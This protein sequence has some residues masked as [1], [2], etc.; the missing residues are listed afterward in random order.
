MSHIMSLL[1]QNWFFHRKFACEIP[2]KIQIPRGTKASSCRHN[3][4]FLSDRWQCSL[5]I[6]YVICSMIFGTQFL[7]SNEEMCVLAQVS[8]SW[9]FLYLLSSKVSLLSMIVISLLPVTLCPGILSTVPWPQA[10]V[11]VTVYIVHCVEWSSEPE[12]VWGRSPGHDW[13]LLLKA[14]WSRWKMLCRSRCWLG[15]QGHEKRAMWL[16]PL[17]CLRDSDLG[18]ILT[19]IEHACKTTSCQH[20]GILGK[21][22]GRG[23]L[24]LGRASRT[25]SETRACHPTGRGSGQA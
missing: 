22:L 19:W 15:D 9:I 3:S 1:F 23:L 2:Y 20:V 18:T 25:S 10:D 21:V 5:C 8:N 16:V 14:K 11:I 4:G 6:L 17:R 7:V 24:E 13:L 12:M